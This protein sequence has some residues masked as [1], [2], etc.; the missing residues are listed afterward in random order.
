MRNMSADNLSGKGL[1]SK[2]SEAKR[3]YMV[4]TAVFAVMAL[5]IF[6]VFIVNKKSFVQQGDGY[7]Q[8][9]KALVYF[10]EYLRQ[11]AGNLFYN[12]KLII[13]QWS[14]SLGLGNDIIT[15]MSYYVIGDPLNLLSAFVKPQHTQYL[16]AALIILR[17]YLSGIAF[18][19]FFINRN[20]DCD[21]YGTAVGA[22]SYAFCGYALYAALKHPYFANP[23]IYMPLILAGVDKILDNKRPYL[24]IFAVALSALSNI[25]FFYMLVLI[26]VFYVLVRLAFTYKKDFKQMIKPFMV[27]SVSS[28]IAVMTASVLFIPVAKQL[29]FDS[30]ISTQSTSFVLYPLG[31]YRNLLT[32]FFEIKTGIN[33]WTLLAYSSICM[34]SV[35]VLFIIKGTNKELKFFFI[36]AS[37]ALFIP[38]AGKAMNGFSYVANRWVFA[39]S[40][41]ISYITAKMWPYVVRMRKKQIIPVAVVCLCYTVLCVVLRI[42]MEASAVSTYASIAVCFAIM[43]I[44][45]LLPDKITAKQHRYVKSAVAVLSVI[46]IFSVSYSYY[47]NAGLGNIN[48]FYSSKELFDSFSCAQDTAII[49]AQKKDG[50]DGFCRY[51]FV[52]GKRN[53]QLYYNT[54]STQYYWSL[55]NSSVHQLRRSMLLKEP[56]P[57]VY[58]NFD[59]RTELLELLNVKYFAAPTD[60][61]MTAPYGFK[62]FLKDKESGFTV[63]KNTNFL[64]LGY[65]Y[66]T[67]MTQQ[68]YDRLSPLQRQES[69]LQSALVED[70]SKIPLENGEKTQSLTC[71]KADFKIKK[72]QKG[73]TAKD[74]S[75][76]VAKPNQS[77]YISVDGN[78]E[79]EYYVCLRGI[80]FEKTNLYDLYMDD[81]ELDPQDLFKKNKWDGMSSKRKLKLL[82][83]SANNLDNGKVK[84]TL[85]SLNDDEHFKTAFVYANEYNQYYSNT[86]DYDINLG[87]FKDGVKTIKITFPKKGVYSFRDISVYRQSMKNYKKQIKSLKEDT[88]S[89]V[90]FYDN[91]IKGNIT[92][93]KDKLLCMSVPYSNGWTAYVDGKKAEII[94]T[95]KMCIGLMLSEGEHSVELKYQMP[96]FKVGAAVS[97]FGIVIL[98]AYVVYFE[99]T[100]KKKLTV[101]T[102]KRKVDAENED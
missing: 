19:F 39:Y 48:A 81:N 54:H 86:H 59:A 52:D 94:K 64:P 80:G 50:D 24:F 85:L 41:I 38:I 75:F 22:L 4:Y 101:K 76:V 74:N 1:K 13:P 53:S 31:Y 9:F 69:L 51:E 43:F 32:S 97:V 14:F 49:K 72:L 2:H 67:V 40:L 73:V 58:H 36:V 17:L 95:N 11:I 30:R 33:Y 25:Y 42:G 46:S 82:S 70:T 37:A 28:A 89:D 87:Y 20:K 92:L 16:Y 60:D 34:I 90:E 66:D 84:I 63:Y 26:T 61:K 5:I 77:V 96:M 45:L 47:S 6:F 12:H 27:V 23:M 100:A 29:I 21:K 65:T 3:Y 71:V 57:Q 102:E 99:V 15:T 91:G 78:D 44:M 55:S 18:S 79:G 56:L 88:L 10:G 83:K 62:K 7:T 93:N 8:H 35:I 98:A 68:Y